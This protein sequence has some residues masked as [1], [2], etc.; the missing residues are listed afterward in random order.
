MNN[1]G[2]MVSVNSA[3]GCAHYWTKKKGKLASSLCG[4]EEKTKDLQS[5]KRYSSKCQRCI[6][7]GKNA[8]KS[9]S[10]KSRNDNLP[11]NFPYTM[12]ELEQAFEAALPYLESEST[13]NQTHASVSEDDMQEL[14]EK[15]E[16][17]WLLDSI[18]HI[19][20]VNAYFSNREGFG[21]PR[22]R[23]EF[24][25]L[26]QIAM[27]VVN[28]GNPNRIRVLFD[29]AADLDDQIYSMMESLS[30]VRDVLARLLTLYPKSIDG[31]S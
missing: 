10:L 9:K 7:A 29:N 28:Y 16:T 19:D 31:D 21:P 8:V 20:R 11:D 4:R 2:W 18:T 25:E 17:T 3:S 13:E 27:E 23:Q 30:S 15:F 26:H 22:I 24:F 12:D 5:K 1:D 14:Y 6:K